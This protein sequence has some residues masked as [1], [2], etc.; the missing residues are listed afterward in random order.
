[1]KEALACREM[2]LRAEQRRRKPPTGEETGRPGR[3]LRVCIDRPGGQDLTLPLNGADVGENAMV[4]LG[5]DAHGK[6]VLAAKDGQRHQNIVTILR[7]HSP[8]P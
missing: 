1:V 4:S 5:R 2:E 7:F 3:K 6:S 8:D